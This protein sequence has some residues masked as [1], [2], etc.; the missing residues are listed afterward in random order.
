M[1]NTHIVLLDN[2]D[3]FTYNLVDQFRSLGHSV[4]VFRNSADAYRLA[5]HI[6][7]LPNAVLVLSPGPG[8]PN[9]AGCMPHLI[10]LM[11]GKVPILGICLGHQAIVESYGGT[12]AGAG[13]IMHGKADMLEHNGHRI[14]AICPLLFPLLVTT[15]W[16]QPKLLNHYMLL[17]KPINSLWRL[18][19]S[20]IKCV[21]FNF[22]P[23]QFSPLK[24]LNC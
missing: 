24:E 22:I 19:M 11:K 18:F 15:H 3:S 7:A 1:N 5:Q 16:L 2:Y 20:K 21:D 6:Q 9:D 14:L 12:V 17:Q 4:T 13:E 10:E 8:A 23:S